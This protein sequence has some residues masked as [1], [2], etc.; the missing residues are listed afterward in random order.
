MANEC[1]D[2]LKY[3]IINAFPSID[4]IDA[5]AFSLGWLTRNFGL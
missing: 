3:A 1:A 2:K 5:K 4:P